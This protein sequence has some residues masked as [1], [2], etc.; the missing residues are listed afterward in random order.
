MP[1][2]SSGYIGS[3]GPTDAQLAIVAMTPGP[4]EVA[5]FLKDGKGRPLIGASGRASDNHLI[6]AGTHRSRTYLTNACKHFLYAINHDGR[7]Y[8]KEPSQEQIVDEQPALYEE[9]ISLPNL[10]CIIAYG[11]VALLALSNFHFSDITRR[12][13]SI[14]ETIF[15]KKMIPTFHPSFYM[16]GEWRFR[17]IVDFDVRRAYKE[18]KF[19]ELRIPIRQFYI[20]PTF[21]EVAEWLSILHNLEERTIAFDIE[22]IRGNLSCIAFSDQVSRA[23][24][25]P[26]VK[27]SYEHYWEKYEESAI[28]TGIARLLS[29]PDIN[30]ITQNGL[31]DAWQL[32]KYGIPVSSNV[33]SFDTMYAHRLLAPDLP[34]K[35][36]FLTSLYT[37]E[38]F[39]K[40]ESGNWKSEIPV[41]DH[42]FWIYNCKDASCTLEVA[43]ALQ[44]DMVETG[45]LD[46]YKEVVQPKWP[47]LLD[48]RQRGIRVH[49]GKLVESRTRLQKERQKLE[50][51]L[52]NVLGWSPNTKSY[53]DMERL[54]NQMNMR[55][56]R[57]ATGR[58]R[59]NEEYMKKYIY[60][61]ERYII[62]GKDA[63][64]A[65]L[66]L[67]QC[68]EITKYRTLESSFLQMQPDDHNFYHP[69]YDLSHAVSGRDSS[70]SDENGGPQLHN[71]PLYIRKLFVPDTPGHIFIQGD[72]KQAETMVVAW[73]A[74]DELRINAFLSN[75]DIHRVNACILF[76]DWLSSD[77]PPEDMLDSIS[78]VCNQCAGVLDLESCRHSER[79][80]AKQSG[81]AF[82]YL[83]G[84]EKFVR[85]QAMNGIFIPITEAK[86]MRSLLVSPSIRRWQ[87]SL[88]RELRETSRL[89]NPLGRR[90]EFYGIL[91]GKMH[92]A[93]LSWKAQSTVSSVIDI[94]IARLW[95]TL[96]GIAARLVTQTHDSVL[97][98]TPD[99][100]I[101]ETIPLM[102]EA[103]NVEM[104]I[105]GR[106]LKIPLEI[107]VG[108]SWGELEKW[109]IR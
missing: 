40:D 92:G 83:M 72:L 7:V 60:E 1:N 86:R 10:N 15:G 82:A 27:N 106:K 69:I 48:M 50:D 103:F 18:S 98:N 99:D 74:E 19:P 49:L 61:T 81:H 25:I 104:T 23:F 45:T 37:D 68:L 12:R 42:Q 9:L 43:V 56:D 96:G 62:P 75:I 88:L 97:I 54:L 78:V 46:Y 76:R 5:L 14:L 32:W 101:N 3:E 4:D 87:Q 100:K 21:H 51:E 36:E 80:A 30:F 79:Y 66:I 59:V 102:E 90:R 63:E 109:Q 47:I 53:I 13:G 34:H 41:P 8:I 84:E 20:E 44:E 22:T 71:I 52:Q 91:D 93:A 95:K 35:L 24:C 67:S 70:K 64:H 105:K 108:Q 58:P 73:D 85:L 6:N 26:F 77:L 94:A 39:Y 89:T 2:Y 16:H 11:Q 31:F 33:N 38:P 17:P 107:S 28:L 65:R 29:R 55:C 57:T